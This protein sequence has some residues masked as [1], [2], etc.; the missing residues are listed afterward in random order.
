MKIA[1]HPS[2]LPWWE[3]IKVRGNHPHPDLLPSR[4]GTDGVPS[5]FILKD[6]GDNHH[7]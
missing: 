4:E 7:R 5:I 6:A 2:P 3:R 1:F